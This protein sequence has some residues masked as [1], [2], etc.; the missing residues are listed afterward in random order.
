MYVGLAFRGCPAGPEGRLCNILRFRRGSYEEPRFRFASRREDV[1]PFSYAVLNFIRVRKCDELLFLRRVRWGMCGVL[2]NRYDV[3]Q[4]VF[5][6][7]KSSG[8][9]VFGCALWKLEW[10]SIM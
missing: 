2:K 4:N 1:N 3:Y 8:W 6:G 10:F 5:F 9:G 7:C